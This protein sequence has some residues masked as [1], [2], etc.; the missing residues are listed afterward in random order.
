[1]K[2]HYIL[3]ILLIFGLQSCGIPDS[4]RLTECSDFYRFEKLSRQIESSNLENIEKFVFYCV[5]P[6]FFNSFSSPVTDMYK[7][8]SEDENVE[9]TTFEKK[10][11]LDTQDTLVIFYRRKSK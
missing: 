2:N 4:S 3:F 9:V 7:E 5:T 8:Y 11:V 6:E 10:V 1:M